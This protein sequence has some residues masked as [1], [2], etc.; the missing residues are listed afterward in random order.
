MLYSGQEIKFALGSGLFSYPAFLISWSVILPFSVSERQV[1]SKPEPDIIKMWTSV[2]ILE[3][4]GIEM[5]H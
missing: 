2:E 5:C 4:W 3:E 1:I